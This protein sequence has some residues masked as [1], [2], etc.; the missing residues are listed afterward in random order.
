LYHRATKPR[1]KNTPD[2]YDTIRP[3]GSTIFVSDHA[4]IIGAP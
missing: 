3:S 4:L 1:E 2:R